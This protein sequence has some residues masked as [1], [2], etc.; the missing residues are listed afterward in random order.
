MSAVTDAVRLLNGES[1]AFAFLPVINYFYIY[2]Q[3]P[4]PGA[5]DNAIFIG[6]VFVSALGFNILSQVDFEAYSGSGSTDVDNEPSDSAENEILGLQ[7][8]AILLL[9][10]IAWFLFFIDGLMQLCTRFTGSSV[11]PELLV[12]LSALV[13]C[14]VVSDLLLTVL[15]PIYGEAESES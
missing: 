6:A 15:L 2:S 8:L 11:W 9:A 1:A 13:I 3:L 7:S 12:V 14:L 10:T 5:I 4:S